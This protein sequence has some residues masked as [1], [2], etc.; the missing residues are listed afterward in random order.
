MYNLFLLQL[1][2]YQFIKISPGTIQQS[3][4][5]L[6][7]QYFSFWNPHS[8]YCRVGVGFLSS[9]MISLLACLLCAGILLA[10]LR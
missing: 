7:D 4:K 8:Q 10:R 2:K 1:I 5:A 9:L 3:T 6:V